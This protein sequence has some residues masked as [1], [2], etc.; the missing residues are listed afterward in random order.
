MSENDISPRKARGEKSKADFQKSGLKI[1]S[2]FLVSSVH[3]ASI[4]FELISF[5]SLNLVT[6]FCI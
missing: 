6:L 4:F 5:L 3:K 2:V 1:V